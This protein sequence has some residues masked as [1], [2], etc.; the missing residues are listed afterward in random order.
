MEN[1]R[2]KNKRMKYISVSLVLVLLCAICVCLL[3]I[4]YNAKDKHDIN[5][6]HQTEV[7]KNDL[8]EYGN[9]VWAEWDKIYRFNRKTDTFMTACAD[10]ECDGKCPMECINNCFAGVH[11]GRLYFCAWQ[12]YTHLT[13]LAY[14]D[15][16]TG[17][18]HV[19]KTMS[20]IEDPTAYLTFI[21]GDWWYYR[22]M[23][24]KDGGDATKPTDYEPYICRISL[25][26]NKD[27]TICKLE[28]T[29]YIMMAAN[30]K[31]VTGGGGKLYIT[32]VDS[33]QKEEL[34]D[35]AQNGYL[36]AYTGMQY[37]D[38]N[39]Y[40]VASSMTRE[41]SELTGQAFPLTFL[42]RINLNNGNVERVVDRPVQNFTLTE[43]GI[44]YVPFKL[45]HI[46]VP[47][48][49]EEHPEQVKL[50]LSDDSLYFCDLD[51]NNEEK[52]YTN[53]E[54]D[55]SY[56]FTVI[57]NTLYGWMFDYNE[58]THEF[59]KTFFGSINLDSGRIVH[60]EKPAEK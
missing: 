56:R 58:E 7:V 51:G 17:E 36:G 60:T 28:D 34:Y 39:I 35:F 44:Y 26:G 49:H 16:V 11:N 10:P 38:C 1:K 59:D 24:I 21:D 25:D 53:D 5:E 50:S 31:I 55:F 48:N 47:E 40:F 15:V 33:K 9:F 18:T 27:Q 57:D 54:L 4:V 13:M 45:R 20:E 14:Q 46:Y 43:Q 12:Q 42:M 32:D 22:C 6:L 37:Y 52:V 41:S 19:I 29:E 8:A 3:C 2:T 30:G 23:L